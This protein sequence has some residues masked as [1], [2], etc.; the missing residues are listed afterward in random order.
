[1]TRRAYTN[2]IASHYNARRFHGAG[3]K[4]VNRRELKTVLGM[5]PA[6]TQ[7]VLDAP[8]GTGRVTLE[9]VKQGHQVTSLDL[10]QDML[11]I[12]RS[13]SENR[14]LVLADAHTLPIVTGSFDA[15]VCLRYLHFYSPAQRPQLEGF[16]QELARV[17][18]PGGMVVIDSN[19][20]SP[21]HL[22]WGTQGLS[23]VYFHR[24]AEMDDLLG[25][26]GLRVIQQQ[27]MFFLAPILYRYLPSFGVQFLDKLEKRVPL[28]WRVR[29]FWSCQK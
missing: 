22:G 25:Q 8:T 23:K 14:K 17:V 27:S 13:S 24:D 18:K 4:Y 5:L 21:R 1:V 19:R 12:V 9:L 26:A 29:V 20:W 7:K 10:S 11:E 6:T 28:S 15:C 16:L 3:G 2:T